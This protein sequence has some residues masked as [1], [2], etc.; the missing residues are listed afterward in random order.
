MMAIKSTNGFTAMLY[1]EENGSVTASLNELD[2]VVNAES[3][4]A[5]IY[6]LAEEIMEY[7]EDFYKE[8]EYWSTA[9][10]RKD[11][12]SYVLETLSLRDVKQLA[13]Q[14]VIISEYAS[15]H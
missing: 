15:E 3:Q 1:H 2:L 11:H 10:N 6:T 7:A 8:F 9:P 4:A 14:I 13:E 12:I 5:A